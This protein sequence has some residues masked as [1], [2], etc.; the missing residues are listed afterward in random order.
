MVDRFQFAVTIS[1]EGQLFSISAM[2]AW[3][4]TQCLTKIFSFAD[5]MTLLT[6]QLALV[7]IEIVIAL[8]TW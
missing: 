8:C 1:T 2:L 5:S 7:E 4:W 6:I 3:I